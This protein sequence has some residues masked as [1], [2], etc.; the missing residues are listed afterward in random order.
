MTR[1]VLMKYTLDHLG[2]AT[3]FGIGHLVTEWDPEYGW[4]VGTPVSTDRCNEVFNTDIENVL[5]DH[6][7][8]IPRL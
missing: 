3:I 4:E 2:L 5:S 6:E 8:T 7:Q 1:E